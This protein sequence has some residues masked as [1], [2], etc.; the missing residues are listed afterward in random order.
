MTL[1][2]SWNKYSLH[3]LEKGHSPKT[4]QGYSDVCK[5]FISFIGPDKDINDITLDN[6]QE[7]LSTIRLGKLSRASIA[8]YTRTIKCY[9]NYLKKYYDIPLKVCLIPIPKCKPK[10]VNILNC[11]ELTEIASAVTAENEWITL[12]NK[13]IILMMYDSGLRQN[14]VCLLKRNWIYSDNTMKVLGKG[15]K[16]RIVPV[17]RTTR[18]FLNAYLAKCPYESEYV[19]VGRRGENLTPNAVKQFMSK[20]AKKL[21]FSISSHKLRHNFATNFCLDQY[22]TVGA[23]DAYKLQIIMGHEDLTTTLGYIHE[24]QNI[25]ASR[26]C[27]SHMDNV[28]T[29]CEGWTL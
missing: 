13:T 29:K 10:L 3:C 2:E 25:V 12:R 21:S 24:A 27:V 5:P 28:I 9:L 16:E 15:N 11:D 17:G 6:V 1:A 23:M 19:F 22:N 20:V 26:Q 18:K 8:S 7:Y 14:E 4:A